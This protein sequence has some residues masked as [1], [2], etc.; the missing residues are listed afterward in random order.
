MRHGVRN[1]V[2]FRLRVPAAAGTHKRLRS[3][4]MKAAL[5]LRRP[6]NSPTITIILLLSPT[7]IP[8]RDP[9]KLWPFRASASWGN[10]RTRPR[11]A[12]SQRAYVT[13]FKVEG[14]CRPGREHNN[15]NNNNN[16]IFR[17]SARPVKTT[18]TEA[19]SLPWPTGH[20]RVRRSS[21]TG[22]SR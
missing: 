9:C 2:A 12:C 6:K 22:F 16:N 10:R 19:A 18:F 13:K 21:V 11:A 4:P 3:S 17:Y 20:G 15:N 8:G 5:G 1:A 14:R 7:G